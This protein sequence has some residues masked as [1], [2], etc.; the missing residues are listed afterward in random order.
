MAGVQFLT[1]KSEFVFEYVSGSSTRRE[2]GAGRP[3]NART[4]L[5]FEH[6][7][8]CCFNGSRCGGHLASSDREGLKAALG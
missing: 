6:H 2:G 8:A 1:R 3:R 5:L 7:A 4:N